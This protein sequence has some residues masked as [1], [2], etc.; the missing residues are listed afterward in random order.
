MSN[1][2]NVRAQARAQHRI[3]LADTSDDPSASALLAAAARITGIHPE[4]VSSGDP[5]LDGAEAVLDQEAESI[6][7]D[8]QIDSLRLP[9]VLAH[10]WAHLWLAHGLCKPCSADQIDP[11]ASDEDVPLGM[12]QVQGYSPEERKEREANVYAR[13]LLLPSDVVRRWFLSERLDAAA[14]AARTGL[15]EAVVRHQLTYAL[16]TPAPR[17]AASVPGAGGSK[18]QV[19]LDDSQRD[20]AFEPEGPVLVE[21]GPGTGKTRTLV[22]R[23]GYLVD[24]GEDPASILGLTFSIKAAAEMRERIAGSHERAAKMT[25]GTF[26]SFGLETLRQ[27]GHLHPLEYP[28]RLK[29]VEPARAL[30]LL[31]RM[32]P[33]LHL[34]H[35]QNLYE[36]TANLK[37]LLDAISRA[38]DE[39]CPPSRYEELARAMLARAGDEDQIEKA[40]KALE[41]ARVYQLYQERLDGERMVDFGDLVF[42]TAELMQTVPEVRSRLS[43]TFQHVL[44]D[45]Y[46][47]VN[48]ASGVLLEELA[49]ASNG[50]SLWVVGDPRQSIYRWR[51]A[52][53]ANL[54]K[55]K[56]LYPHAKVRVLGVNYRSRKEIVDLVSGFVPEMRVGAGEA[57]TPWEAN[58]GRGGSVALEI[59]ADGDAETQGI[60]A[61]IKRHR[62]AGRAYADQAVLCRSHTQLARVAAGLERA[63]VPVLYLGDLFERPEI[64]DLL[65]L[66][67]LACHGDGRGLLRVA[68][69]PEYDVPVPDVLALL[70][71]AKKQD[72]AFPR[73]LTL[74][75]ELEGLSDHARAG[76]LRISE[77]LEGICYGENA[78]GMLT[79]YLFNRSE[80]FRILCADA[81]V[82]GQQRRLAIF[83]FLEFT[84]QNRRMGG[85]GDA[86]DEPKKA[87][88]DYVRRLEVFG[89][90]KQL[91]NLPQS[92]AAVDAVRLLTIHGSK[93]LE[94]PVVY[95]PGLGAGMFPTNRKNPMCP[96]PTGMVEDLGGGEHDEEEEC[97][98]FVALSRARDSLCLSRPA[99]RGGKN[100]NPS[101]LLTS[102]AR[103]LPRAPGSPVTWRPETVERPSPTALPSS[104]PIS[105]EERD[106][107]A[108]QRCPR[109]YLYERVFGLG[110]LREDSVY[111]E[112]HKCVYDVIRWIQ[113][114]R[115]GASAP[116]LDATLIQLDGVW[117]KHGLVDH[118]YERMYREAAEVMIREAHQRF[119]S[120]GALAERPSWVIELPHGSVR[121]VP[122]LVISENPAEAPTAYYLRTG[123]LGSEELSKAIYGLYHRAYAKNFPEQPVNVKVVS[124]S[125]G[126]VR[127]VSFKTSMEDTRVRKYGDAVERIL[128]G[129]FS[130]D[131]AD[132]RM[133]PRCPHYFICPCGGDQ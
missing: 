129:E 65:A 106:L 16:L 63:G 58:R 39:L 68:E 124:L 117:A 87:F 125:T 123:R 89:E 70:A 113:E 53:S 88:L 8:Q 5:L 15:P 121:L 52:S 28:K 84:H 45:E 76:L 43:D 122:D 71:E 107:Y 33:Q 47:D 95:V 21:A 86:Q 115:T 56:E 100:S 114:E 81:S 98:F 60:A 41:V 7:Y 72:R 120:S 14:I 99:M 17:P 80:Y 127:P 97:L 6:F 104:A 112:V 48:R 40:E 77:H 133:C 78:W 2:T 79:E 18:G 49:R 20:A 34:V 91:R 36:P 116:D 128:R 44:V 103:H 54:R 42:R 96:A 64:R 67:S 131:P 24:R 38:K 111:V 94:F 118:P 132:E 90:E 22:A 108:Y 61:E 66:L 102:L 75:R 83:Q 11:E 62:E 119:A 13:E 92:A 59:G 57:F 93:G 82:A 3:L 69:F 4:P 101:R 19:E 105:Y 55:L 1:W 35:Y 109:Q 74:A 50:R 51:G 31:E 25:V 29:V 130:P 30:F 126:E 85:E 26:H 10:E 110:G 37:H 46:Q 32:L 23:A 73:A 12:A 27:Y 9:L